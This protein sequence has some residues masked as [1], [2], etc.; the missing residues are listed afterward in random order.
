M[1]RQGCGGDGGNDGGSGAGLAA[2]VAMTCHISND[3][4]LQ[5]GDIQLQLLTRLAHWLW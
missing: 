5:R 2:A 3:A 1:H 4:C